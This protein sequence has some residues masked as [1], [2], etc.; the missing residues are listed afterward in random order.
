M[1]KASAKAAGA[2]ASG[3]LSWLLQAS[4][5]ISTP[6]LP[7]RPTIA[8]LLTTLSSLP[9]PS[10]ASSTGLQFRPP[11]PPPH[12]LSP[13]SSTTA[14]KAPQP[15]PAFPTLQPS[16]VSSTMA[17]NFFTTTLTT[18]VRIPQ[19]FHRRRQFSAVPPSTTSTYLPPSPY[20][21]TTTHLILTPPYNYEPIFRY[22]PHAV[23]CIPNAITIRCEP[24]NW[25]NKV[26]SSAVGQIAG[27]EVVEALR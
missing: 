1:D 8:N 9:L 24:L 17:S 22:N 11:P 26:E 10:P 3:P 12:L 19:H 21:S 14:A 23:L 13:S 6:L 20:S 27:T 18:S 5:L 15:T 25:K 2:R 16:P 7:T 4:R